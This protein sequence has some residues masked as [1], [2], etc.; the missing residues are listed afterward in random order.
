VD[1]EVSEEAFDA[2][3]N[4]SSSEVTLPI[5]TAV[6]EASTAVRSE[7]ITQLLPGLTQNPSTPLLEC[8]LKARHLHRMWRQL[9][10]RVV[11][12][13]VAF[14]ILESVE[15]Q[16]RPANLGDLITIIRYQNSPCKGIS[17]DEGICLSD[18]NDC[19]RRKGT[20]IGTCA[21]GLST[22]CL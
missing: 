9:V 10:V 17:G 2:N 11:F 6:E 15:A 4:P 8:C 1:L 18:A 3:Y 19:E 13:L 21:R 5:A 12:T 14:L 22:C 20:N 16:N 7:Y